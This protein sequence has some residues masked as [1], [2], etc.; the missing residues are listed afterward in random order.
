M[1]GNRFQI[2]YNSDNDDDE[3]EYYN[4]EDEFDQYEEDEYELDSAHEWSGGYHPNFPI[5][6]RTNYL[7]ETGPAECLNCAAFGCYRG[8]FIGYCANCAHRYRGTRGRGFIDVCMEYDNPNTRQWT[9]AFETYLSGCDF[10]RFCPEQQEYWYEQEMNN[11][12]IHDEDDHD[13]D[14]DD[15]HEAPDGEVLST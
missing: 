11:I 9:S 15:D 1:T 8:N 3:L 5:E 7:S 10:A 2:H 13:H 14:Y 12:I 6:W 4:E